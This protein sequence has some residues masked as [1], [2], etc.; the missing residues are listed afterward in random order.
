M[1]SRLKVEHLIN[2]KFSKMR[3]QPSEAVFSRHTAA[4]IDVLVDEYG[5]PREFKTTSF[6][7]RKTAVW[8]ERLT[9]RQRK[10]GF[11]FLDMSKYDEAVEDIKSFVAIIDSAILFKDQTAARVQ[12]QRGILLTSVAFLDIVDD[13]LTNFDFEFVLGGRFTSEAVE[14]LFSCVRMRALA[15]SGN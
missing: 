2:N 5:N 14:N 4:A 15:P 9:T 6:F 8:Y 1:Q 3:V 11:S 10:M 7:I 12:L 13:L